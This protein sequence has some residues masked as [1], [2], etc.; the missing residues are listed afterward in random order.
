MSVSQPSETALGC[1]ARIVACPVLFS[2]LPRTDLRVPVDLTVM[3]TDALPVGRSHM[4]RSSRSHCVS[5]SHLPVCRH[6]TTAVVSD[7]EVV[8]ICFGDA[9]GAR[10]ACV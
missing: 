6:V 3:A 9:L 8:L 4:C 7:D 1:E 10:T 2:Q 5:T